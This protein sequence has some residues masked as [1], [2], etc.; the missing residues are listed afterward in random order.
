MEAPAGQAKTRYSLGI[1][2]GIKPYSGGAYQRGTLAQ[3]AA[4]T[5]CLRAEIVVPGIV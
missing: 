3:E 5:G 2:D 4:H 1:P